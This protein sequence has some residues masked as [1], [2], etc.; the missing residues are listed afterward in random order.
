[1]ITPG[2]VKVTQFFDSFNPGDPLQHPIMCESFM[3]EFPN[4][5][6]AFTNKS[7]DGG[8]TTEYFNDPNKDLRPPEGTVIRWGEEGDDIIVDSPG[9]HGKIDEK[10][11]S[12]GELS[13]FRWFQK[14]LGVADAKSDPSPVD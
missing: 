7:P 12:S 4:G 6:L 10:G 11:R 13:Q 2:G 1:M 3:C 9:G 5:V 8:W 14:L